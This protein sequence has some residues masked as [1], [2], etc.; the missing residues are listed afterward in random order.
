MALYCTTLGFLNG[1]KIVKI[2][3]SFMS[4]SMGLNHDH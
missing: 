1:V 4:V 2:I 3:D